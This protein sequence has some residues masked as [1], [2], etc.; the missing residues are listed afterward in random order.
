MFKS[1]SSTS[2]VSEVIFCKASATDAAVV[3]SK[4]CLLS[5]SANVE[6]MTSSSSTT[7]NRRYMLDSRYS[8]F[9]EPGFD[10][11]TS[12]EDRQHALLIISGERPRAVMQ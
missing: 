9:G 11:C 10:A 6:R 2:N 5:I 3:T 1:D 4:P 12:Y 8:T 7:N